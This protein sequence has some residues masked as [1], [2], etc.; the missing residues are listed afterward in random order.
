M[1]RFL[2][3]KSK[4][5]LHYWLYWKSVGKDFRVV[6]VNAR[7]V[8]WYSEFSCHLGHTHPMKECLESSHTSI[9]DPAF[10]SCVPMMVKYSGP[11]YPHGRSRWNYWLLTLAWSSHGC[12]GHVECKSAD[13]KSQSLSNSVFEINKSFFKTTIEGFNNTQNKNA[14]EKNW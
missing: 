4:K 1:W 2:I 13:G 7:V 9:S 11:F 3:S 5:F 14:Q 10:C 6:K 12:C 8:L